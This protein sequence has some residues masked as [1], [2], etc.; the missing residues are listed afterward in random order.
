MTNILAERDVQLFLGCVVLAL[1]LAWWT[2]VGAR[3]EAP[4]WPIR[5]YLGL[6]RGSNFPGIADYAANR[7][8]FSRREQYLASF[9]VWFF[10]LFIAATF[11]FGCGRRGC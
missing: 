10:I 4:V 9:F 1:W 6:F 5:V 11:F 3:S 8:S 2:V 7:K